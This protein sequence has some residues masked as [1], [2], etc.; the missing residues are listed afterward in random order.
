[1]AM[2][3]EQLR[4]RASFSLLPAGEGGRSLPISGGTSYR[5]TH[6]FF[7]PENRE[8]AN[9]SIELPEGTV[10]NPGGAVEI[11]LSFLSWPRLER[12]LR[13][14]RK[15]LIQEGKQ[16]VGIGTVLEVLGRRD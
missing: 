9:A 4:V 6:N 15:W 12:E 5:P 14:G 16:V 11:E 13:P 3:G 8:M 10:L 1:M 7:G 2:S